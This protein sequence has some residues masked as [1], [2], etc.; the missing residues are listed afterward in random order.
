MNFLVS[1]LSFRSPQPLLAAVHIVVRALPKAELFPS[2]LKC[3]LICC[4]YSMDLYF[5]GSIFL[6]WSVS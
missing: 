1:S 5:L 3:K 2:H 6:K 4:V